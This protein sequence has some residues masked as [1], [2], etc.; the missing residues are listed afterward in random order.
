VGLDSNGTKGLLYAKVQGVDYSQSAMIGRHKL[1]L[2]PSQLKKNLVELGVSF[3][4]ETVSSVFEKDNGYS[5]EFLRCLGANDIHSFDNSIYEGA[6][7]IHDMNQGIPNNLMDQ[8][9]MVLDAGT[10]EHIFNFPVAIKN[11][12]EM[13]KVG[14]H[15]IGIL[16]T[17]NFVGHG[18]YQ[19]SPELYF[20]VFNKENG[21]ELVDVIIF[22][23]ELKS[24]WFKVQSPMSVKGRITLINNR[25]PVYLLVIAKKMKKC[26]IFKHPPQQ[27]DYI[28]MWNESG[29]STIHVIPIKT[30]LSAIV[31]RYIPLCL[32]PFMR[33]FY[34]FYNSGF[35]NKNFFKKMLLKNSCDQQTFRN[36]KNN[37]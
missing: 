29:K 15:Y 20:S 33:R 5:E 7:H 2:T 34:H 6:T 31:K 21:F 8:Y 23:D 16:P 19:F 13:L 36:R 14:G 22:E 26:E 24:D 37:Y 28:S 17:N 35:G 30:R 9:S 27:S 25:T 11:C 3:D 32:Q 12:M 18:F 4:E 1:H 10:L